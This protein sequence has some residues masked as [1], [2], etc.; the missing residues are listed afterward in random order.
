MLNSQKFA[1][2]QV[3]H[4]IVLNYSV[5]PHTVRDRG[6]REKIR[7]SKFL[8]VGYLG[9]RVAKAADCANEVKS[10]LAGVLRDKLSTRLALGM[11]TMVKS[12]KVL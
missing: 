1:L 4:C 5:Y 11:A 3:T 12:V 8:C 2:S 9:C 10:R 7:A 6:E